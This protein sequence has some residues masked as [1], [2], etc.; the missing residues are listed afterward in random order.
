MPRC[1][2]ASNQPAHDTTRTR[3]CPPIN[4][5]TEQHLLRAS[6]K[7]RSRSRPANRQEHNHNAVSVPDNHAV[8]CC[9]FE[10]ARDDPASAM[11]SC[12]AVSCQETQA[13]QRKAY[14]MVRTK[15]ELA[16]LLVSQH[17]QKHKR[18]CWYTSYHCLGTAAAVDCAG[19]IVTLSCCNGSS[20]ALLPRQLLR[21]PPP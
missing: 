19:S 4:V 14:R 20:A 3:C 10:T 1:S 6:C 9:A 16:Q 15:L 18:R 5:Q 2:A 12:V 7:L 8:L 21:N 11:H 13:R 17:S